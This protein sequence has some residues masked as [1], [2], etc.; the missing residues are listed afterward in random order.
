M[1]SSRG[2]RCRRRR[3]RGGRAGR[4]GSWADH[5]GGGHGLCDFHFPTTVR[6]GKARRCPMK[7]LTT[8]LFAGLLLVGCIDRRTVIVNPETPA[9]SRAPARD[10][11]REARE[12][13]LRE[14]IARDRDAELGRKEQEA[15]CLA[16]KEA[17]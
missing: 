1:P 13:A 11:E 6:R 2:G 8:V 16:E 4:A 3:R 5:T 17:A 10:F 9:V 15:R 12:A 7:A 14:H